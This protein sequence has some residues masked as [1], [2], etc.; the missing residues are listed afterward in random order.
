MHVE[1]FNVLEWSYSC[2]TQYTNYSAFKYDSKSVELR[3]YEVTKT[4]KQ[5]KMKNWENRE[6]D[7]DGK[8]RG[9]WRNKEK[10]ARS[11]Q[12]VMNLWIFSRVIALAK[13][14][15]RLRLQEVSTKFGSK[16]NISAAPVLGL[17]YIIR[18]RVPVGLGRV[19]NLISSGIPENDR[20]LHHSLISLSSYSAQRLE[21]FW[22]IRRCS[23]VAPFYER[24]SSN[25]FRKSFSMTLV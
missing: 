5:K 13:P 4:L 19:D 7:G 9:E 11:T 15:V 20:R 24:I 1:E 21:R 2:K 18:V 23:Q 10:N 3:I 14:L 22:L 8:K 6:V 12:F 17:R 25:G 16:T